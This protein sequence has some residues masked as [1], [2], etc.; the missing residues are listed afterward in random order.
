MGREIANATGAEINDENE[1]IMATCFSLRSDPKRY[2]TLL[3]DL[4]RSANLGRDE[5]PETLTEAFNVVV[6]ESGEYDTIGGRQQGSHYRGRSSCRGCS[7]HNFLF[8]QGGG[9]RVEYT[10]YN[11]TGSDEIIAGTDNISHSN[12]TCFSCKFIDHYRYVCPY[13]P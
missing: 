6:R 1:K 11:D 9:D 4:K 10:R 13:A 12:I 3:E 7:N 5:Y 2:R 8:V